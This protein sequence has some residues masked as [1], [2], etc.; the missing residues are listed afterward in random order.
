MQKKWI[1]LLAAC[2]LLI[3]LFTV[4]ASAA[5]TSISFSSSSVTV[6]STVTVTATFSGGDQTLGAVDAYLT[7]DPGVL[8]FVSGNSASGG[9]GSVSIV[10]FGDGSAKTLSYAI[11]FKAIGAGS[12]A[13]FSRRKP[14]SELWRRRGRRGG[15]SRLR[16]QRDADGRIQ[17]WRRRRQRRRWWPEYPSLPE[18][19]GTRAGRTGRGSDRFRR[20]PVSVADAR[21]RG[22]PGWF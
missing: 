13:N 5:S 3:G 2:A 6:G 10:G 11:T 12:S 21:R 7:Y 1:S 9:A 19:S 4:P 18:R 16:Q 20:E 15:S 22:D 14:A 17:Q 8:Q